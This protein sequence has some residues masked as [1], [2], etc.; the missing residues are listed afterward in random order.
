MPDLSELLCILIS[1]NVVKRIKYTLPVGQVTLWAMYESNWIMQNVSILQL[2]LPRIIL[3]YIIPCRTVCAQGCR[4]GSPWTSG[5]RGCTHICNQYLIDEDN[6]PVEKVPFE[7][8]LVG[9]LK[10][11][12]ANIVP[13]CKIS[14]RLASTARNQVSKLYVSIKEEETWEMGT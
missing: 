4:T 5:S 3:Y 8:F 1:E 14:K 10:Q 7:N 13:E 12:V 11:T 2:L 6:F 9:G